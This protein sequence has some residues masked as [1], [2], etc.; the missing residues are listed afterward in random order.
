[1]AMALFSCRAPTNLTPRPSSV[2]AKTAVSSLI[3]PNTTR[4]PRAWMSSASAWNTGTMRLSCMLSSERL[5]H[6]L[7]LRLPPL[8]Q[9][10]DVRAD[11]EMPDAHVEEVFRLIRGGDLGAG[12]HA[13]LDGGFEHAALDHAK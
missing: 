13:H 2:T 8:V 11:G 12:R 3:S 6:V 1:M 7:T 9:D 5:A 4:T 10:G